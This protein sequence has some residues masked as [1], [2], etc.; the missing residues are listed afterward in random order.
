MT[1]DPRDRL[2]LA[3]YPRSSRYDA[4]WLIDNLMGP[5]PLWLLEWLWPAIDLP[6]GSRVLDLGCGKALTS[7]FLAREYGVQVVAADLWIPPGENWP[8]IVEAGCADSVIPI[9][10]DARDLKFAQGYFDAVVSIDAYHY[11]GT[12]VGY[13]SY[14]AQFVRPGGMVG[15]ASVGVTSDFEKEEPPAHLREYWDPGF[16]LWKSPQW[17][18]LHWNRSGVVDV[19]VAELLDGGWAEWLL[20]EE[21]CRDVG[22]S[23]SPKEIEMLRADAGWHLGFVRVAGRRK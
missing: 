20:W 21:V 5:N 11:F 1:D 14:L 16:W 9:H 13:L 19:E 4:Q 10:A 7:I 8:R 15:V 18:Q 3:H 17:W 22:G 12:A 23:H 6:P 2:A